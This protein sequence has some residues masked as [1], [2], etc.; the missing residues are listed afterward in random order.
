V[1]VATENLL[2]A[3][4]T[5][6]APTR[7]HHRRRSPSTSPLPAIARGLIIAVLGVLAGT[8]ATAWLRP[9]SGGAELPLFRRLT[10]ERGILRGARFI[11][12]GSTVVYSAA[13][14]G[15]LLKL[16]V[17]RPSAGSSTA[18]ELPPGHLFSASHSGE[19]AISLGHTFDGWLGSGTLA[20]TRLGD[21]RPRQLFENVREAEWTPDGKTM[22]VV[23]RR[24]GRDQLE[25]PTGNVV[26]STAGYISTP[27][28]SPD[29]RRLAFGDHPVYGDDDGD[30]VL[31]DPS[32]TRKTLVG[33]LVDIRGLAWAVGGK[34]L[35]FSAVAD[36]T[37]SLVSLQAV[38]MMG[39]RRSVLNAPISLALLD[40]NAAGRVLVSAET[41]IRHVEVLTPGS[42]VPRDLSVL[43]ASSARAITDGSKELLLSKSGP[44]AVYLQR[45]NQEPPTPLGDGEG[46]DLSSDGRWALSIVKTQPSRVLLL[47][48]GGG[49][50]RELPNP[51]TLTIA[52]AKFLPNAEQV[53]LLGSRSG[54]PW[55]AYLQNVADGLIM[56]I[57]DPGVSFL[58][59][60]VIA[61]TADGRGVVL[62]DPDGHV[63]LFPIEG[64]TPQPI[65]G[66]ADGEYPLGWSRDGQS[67]FV[68]RGSAPPWRIER[69]DA[70]TGQRVLLREIAALQSAGVGRSHVAI[71]PDGEGFVHS[72]SQ[73]LSNLYSVDGLH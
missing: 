35:W 26:Y 5:P 53:V 21:E 59:S 1:A 25:W 9:S 48:T 63:R 69:L 17:T 56:P 39:Q 50:A 3:S 70:R 57:T 40:V 30:I 23:R 11:D 37:P 20:Q 15:S 12:E 49:T 71:S 55:R 66:L 18:L 73:L 52:A 7:S 46:F 13:W 45:N 24:R 72:Y 38:D 27:R 42:S 61:T 28:F 32:G 44:N 64:G 54:D 68:T 65:A 6:A 29:G 47:P 60:G 34:E 14:N 19:L 31:I 58:P 41:E 4:N 51:G 8:T 62:T 16:Y 33:N 43:D 2:D 36:D 10:F 67:M 22:A